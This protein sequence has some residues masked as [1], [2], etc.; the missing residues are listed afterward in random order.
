[1]V[2]KCSILGCTNRKDREKELEFYRLPAVITNQ[3]E[4]CEKLS[5]E[6][7]RV[8][9]ANIGQDFENKNLQNVRVCSAHFVNGKLRYF[10]FAAI[11]SVIY[12]HKNSAICLNLPPF[13]ARLPHP[14]ILPYDFKC[15]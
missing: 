8:W 15:H 2:V 13:N 9:L 3:G 11:K 1:M 10:A 12:I 7:R 4:G 5:N 14:L 6:R